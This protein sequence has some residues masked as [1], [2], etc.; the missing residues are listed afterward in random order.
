MWHGLKMAE[1]FRLFK[2]FLVFISVIARVRAVPVESKIVAD[3]VM[4]DVYRRNKIWDSLDETQ[5][6]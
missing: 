3:C 1:L 2:P 6:W 5:S 4:V